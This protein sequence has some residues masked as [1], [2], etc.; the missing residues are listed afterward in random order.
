MSRRDDGHHDID[1]ENIYGPNACRPPGV[2]ANSG[3]DAYQLAA[4]AIAQFSQGQPV[5]PAARGS[6]DAGPLVVARTFNHRAILRESDCM[7]GAGKL[8]Y[9]AIVMVDILKCLAG[10]RIDLVN[11]FGERQLHA[12]PPFASN[13][14]LARL[15]LVVGRMTSERRCLT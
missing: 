6:L 13:L 5:D 2:P 1:Q 3:S 4:E 14:A 15:G 12:T 11:V 10:L 8:F 7:R 9:A